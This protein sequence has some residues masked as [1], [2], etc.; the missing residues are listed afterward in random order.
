MGSV[1]T[2]VLTALLVIVVVIAVKSYSK[3]LVSGCCGGGDVPK[4]RKVDKNP[5]H[6]SYHVMLQIEGMT[7][8]NCA[9]QVENALNAI[10]GVWAEVDLKQ[11]RAKVRQKEQIPVEKLC[12][13][14]EKAGYQAKI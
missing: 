3:K 13:A 4:P 2:A 6:Y 14:V 10:D 8:E 11:N 5:D 7:C 12:A 9:K 1:A